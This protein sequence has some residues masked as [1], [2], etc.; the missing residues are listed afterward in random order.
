MLFASSFDLIALLPCPIL[1]GHTYCSFILMKAK[2]SS[3]VTAFFCDILCFFVG[4]KEDGARKKQTPSYNG[5]RALS[6]SALTSF[7]HISSCCSEGKFCCEDPVENSLTFVRERNRVEKMRSEPIW[8][9]HVQ[10]WL[11]SWCGEQQMHFI[12]QKYTELISTNYLKHSTNHTDHDDA[13]SYCRRFSASHCRP[14]PRRAPSWCE[15]WAHWRTQ[16]QHML[17]FNPLSTM[18][19]TRGRQ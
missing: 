3:S 6:S 16:S 2:L 18:R 11:D 7:L 12:S 19:A 10:L 17:V 15:S 4:H 13:P 8:H 9:R 14:H 5:G 1:G